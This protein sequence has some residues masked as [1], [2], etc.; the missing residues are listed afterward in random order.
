MHY[1]YT[2]IIPLKSIERVEKV[3]TTCTITISVKA[4]IGHFADC[5]SFRVLRCFESLSLGIASED[6]CTINL[7]VIMRISVE[8]PRYKNPASSEKCEDIKKKRRR[9]LRREVNEKNNI[10]AK[11]MA[12]IIRIKMHRAL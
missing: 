5:Q 11:C 3:E 4:L 9:K 2:M 12:L 10:E 1:I 6:A 7:H 8:L